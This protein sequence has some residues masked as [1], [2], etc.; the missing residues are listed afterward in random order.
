MSSPES[1]V[2]VKLVF[3]DRGAFHELVVELPAELLRR[4]ERIIDALRGEPAITA[5]L[6]VD[7]RRLVA[8]HVL[9]GDP[10]S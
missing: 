6:Y 5:D 9:N 7:P 2:A 1:R 4:H 3:A 8:A 10:D